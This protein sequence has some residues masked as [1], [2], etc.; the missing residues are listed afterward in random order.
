MSRVSGDNLEKRI[1]VG[2]KTMILAARDS[3]R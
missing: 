3:P 2:K 1:M